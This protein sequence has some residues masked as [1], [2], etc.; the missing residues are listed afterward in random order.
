MQSQTNPSSLGP[1]PELPPELVLSILSFACSTSHETALNISLVSSWVRL[2][3]L[4]YVFST[5]VQRAGIGAEN[6]TSN[7]LSSAL[8]SLHSS[9]LRAFPNTSPFPSSSPS[10]FVAGREFLARGPL[11][12]AIRPANAP[13]LSR[14]T[15]AHLL[16]PTTTDLGQYVRHLWI[17]SID[18]MASPGE[19][20]IFNVCTNIEDV[21]LAA[22]SLRVLYNLTSFGKIK[23][24]GMHTDKGVSSLDQHQIEASSADES[25]DVEGQEMAPPTIGAA[26]HIRSVLLTK[27]TFRYDW[28]FLVDMNAN[29][30]TH[31]SILGNITHLRLIDMEK[32]PYI[33]LEYLPNLTHLAL[34]YLQ[35]RTNNRGD[36]LRVPDLVLQPNRPTV[37]GRRGAPWGEAP[38]SADRDTTPSKLEMIVLT[39]DEREWLTEPWKYGASIKDQ[40]PRGLFKNLRARAQGTDERLHVLLSPR[41]GR[42]YCSEWAGAARGI[43][44]SLWEVAAK[45]CSR[46]EYG[47]DLPELFP[48][49]PS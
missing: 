30:N 27:H 42:D 36:T 19:L 48:R 45:A 26:S 2:T 23:R 40:S 39:V 5:V 47:D 4:P 6:A 20:N 22:G 15:Y 46:E 32:S 35:L 3:V 25:E 38:S 10:S 8:S 14:K 29:S 9:P 24:K 28:H 43:E 12:G 13:S 16:P 34:P 7:F 21:A 44:D 31:T 41:L 1:F 49:S 37:V 18:M 33:P 11:Q 17:E